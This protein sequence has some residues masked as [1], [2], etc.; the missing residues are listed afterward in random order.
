[1]AAAR[2]C[3]GL[4]W[5]GS[6]RRGRHAAAPGRAPERGPR[7]RQLLPP[8]ACRRGPGAAGPDHQWAG[9]GHPAA[10]RGLGAHCAGGAARGAA[11]GPGHRGVAG[12][13]GQ[14]RGHGRVAPLPGRCAADGHCHRH[15]RGPG[16]Q[17]PRPRG[18][19]PPRTARHWRGNHAARRRHGRQLG[20][21]PAV[22][23]AQGRADAHAAR[24]PRRNLPA[25][26]AG[27]GGGQRLGGAAERPGLPQV[28]RAEGRRAPCRVARRAG[29]V[30]AGSHLPLCRRPAR[31]R[32]VRVAG[33]LRG[34]PGHQDRAKVQRPRQRRRP[35]RAG[36]HRHGAPGHGAHGV[37]QRLASALLRAAGR[38]PPSRGRRPAERHRA[39][40][41]HGPARG[42]V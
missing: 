30:G 42:A 28:H 13:G 18:V 5:R 11:C 39:G 25:A 23:A 36:P 16:E 3:S 24:L 32:C 26:D 9:N 7:G 22:G 38:P 19:C 17:Q 33:A 31:A 1:G 41:P 12:A 6:R 10:Q 20:H 37:V 14:R 35:C 34:R 4:C 2:R 21:R 15:S 8:P 27:P 29:P 40:P